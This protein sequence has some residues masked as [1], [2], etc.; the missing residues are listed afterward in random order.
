MTSTNTTPERV[1]CSIAGIIDR[2]EA[3][4]TEVPAMDQDKLLDDALS[5]LWASSNGPRQA[6]R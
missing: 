6:S 4:A 5:V 3:L 1:E 2:V